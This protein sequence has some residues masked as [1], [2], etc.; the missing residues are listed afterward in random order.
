[1]RLVSL[2]LAL[3]AIASARPYSAAERNSRVGRFR[4]EFAA[5]VDAFQ[6]SV[7][8]PNP[9]PSVRDLTNGALGILA[10]GRPAGEAEELMRMAFRSQDMTVGTV[11]WQM[12]HPEI[13]D[14]NA[15]EFAC[16]AVGPMLL[17]YGQ[18]L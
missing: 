5:S 9:T 12:G 4:R 1:M 15:I 8:R 13:N 2:L 16:Q 7:A 18:S 17:H 14:A 3:S 6:K 11:P 10:L